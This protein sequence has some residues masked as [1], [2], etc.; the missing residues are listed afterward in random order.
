MA[1]SSGDLQ[2]EATWAELGIMLACL[3]WLLGPKWETPLEIQGFAEYPPP[4]GLPTTFRAGALGRGRG[5]DK[6][7]PRDW[8]G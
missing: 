4:S 5:G 6:S 8:E 7:L 1:D 3:A 2:L